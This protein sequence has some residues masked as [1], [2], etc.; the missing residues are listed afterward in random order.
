VLRQLKVRTAAIIR[1]LRARIIRLDHHPQT[2]QATEV[3]PRDTPM[4][5][6]PL[7]SASVIAATAAAS[8]IGPFA[9]SAIAIAIIVGMIGMEGI[10]A[11][12]NGAASTTAV[13]AAIVGI[14]IDDQCSS[15][16]AN[17]H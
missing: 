6:Q 12:A 1:R 14:A 10:G 8:A 11:S 16:Q 9:G 5:E 3:T 2:L 17:H 15:Q 13:V 4:S 7:E